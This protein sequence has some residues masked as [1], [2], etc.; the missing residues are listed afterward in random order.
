MSDDMIAY[1][2]A[3]HPGKHRD[4]VSLAALFFGLF[5]GPIVWSGNLMLTYALGNQACYPGDLPFQQPQNGFG[6]VWAFVLACYFLS[7]AI[8]IAAF[9]V[10]L[11]SW[12]AVGT[13]S[14]G[15][16]GDLT[17]VGEGRTRFLAIIGMAFGMLFFAAVLF[18]VP[19][20][21]ILPL[22]EF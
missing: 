16:W 21:L 8:C 5:A 3:A 7:L 4:R 20:V 15:H 14:A 13:E 17:D 12:R 2:A 11:R 19:A 1:S 6:W 9:V 10:S 18:G 22:C